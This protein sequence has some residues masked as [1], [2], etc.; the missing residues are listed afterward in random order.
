MYHSIVLSKKVLSVFLVKGVPKS[1]S[2]AS[3]KAPD[4][5]IT[6]YGKM[7]CSGA[8]ESDWAQSTNT[9]RAQFRYEAGT[10]E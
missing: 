1:P 5:V 9:L 6:F 3:K 2:Y 10:G 7:V 4:R 8:K